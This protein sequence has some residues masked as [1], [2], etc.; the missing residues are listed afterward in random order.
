MRKIIGLLLA[1]LMSISCF[2]AT[3]DFVDVNT[4]NEVLVEAVDL[5]DYMGVAKGTSE[6]TFGADDLVTREQFVKM[7]VLAFGVLLHILSINH[8]IN[9]VCTS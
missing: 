9:N 7:T 4:D 8:A 2:A 5:L 3:T 1:V 6:S